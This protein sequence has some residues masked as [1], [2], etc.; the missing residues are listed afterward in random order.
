MRSSFSTSFF[1]DHPWV[2]TLLL[3]DFFVSPTGKKVFALV[4][5]RGEKL[6]DQ[7]VKGVG[8]KI[9]DAIGVSFPL[10]SLDQ[11]LI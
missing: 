6:A 7:T 8:C 3:P 4:K 10:L 11:V 5:A 1:L 9:S 2:P